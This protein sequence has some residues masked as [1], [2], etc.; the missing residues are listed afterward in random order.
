MSSLTL[1]LHLSNLSLGMTTLKLHKIIVPVNERDLQLLLAM[2]IGFP[3]A[4]LR[5]FPKLHRSDLTRSDSC[6]YKTSVDCCQTF[7]TSEKLQYRV[8]QFVLEPRLQ[9]F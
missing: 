3:F 6:L 1:V 5:R 4:S 8:N 2:L 7:T 9:V